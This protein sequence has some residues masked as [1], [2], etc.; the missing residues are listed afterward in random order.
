MKKP[1]KFFQDKKTWSRMKDIVLGK[2]LVPYISK[3]KK[4]K[5]TIIV[6]DGFAG[7][8]IYKDKSHGSPMIICKI[9]E[10]YNENQ[11]VKTVGFFIEKN[12]ECFKQLELNIKTYVDKKIAFAVLDDFRKII[13][14]ILSVAQDSPI[15]F[16]LDPFG[17]AGL[18]LNHLEK[19][20]EKVEMSS[21]EVLVNFNYKTVIREEK[22]NPQLIDNVFGNNSWKDILDDDSLDDNQKEK[23]IVEKYKDIYRK[24][25]FEFVA[26]CPIMYKDDKKAKYYLIFATSH[27]DGL[28]IMND[29]MGNVYK[30]FYSKGRLFNVIEPDLSLLEKNITD[31]IGEAE[32]ITRGEIKEKMIPNLFLIYTSS[33]Y[34]QV[35]TKMLKEKTIHSKNGKTRINDNVPLSLKSFS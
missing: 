25:N 23:K 21:T 15:F 2:Y 11:N 1:I 14:E 26:S 28:K 12:K 9:L 30:D 13:P 18:E 16:Y 33:D 19:I 17:I 22:T 31:I 10:D 4:F 34:N 35:I 6:V 20:F 3:L 27:F 29:I 8:G 7:C 24:K 32:I 5:K